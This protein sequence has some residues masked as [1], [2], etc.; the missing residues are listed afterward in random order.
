MRA[1]M[2]VGAPPPTKP[3]L[4]R[5]LWTSMAIPRSS[6]SFLR[7]STISF[8][9]SDFCIDYTFYPLQPNGWRYPLVGGT[10]CRCFAGTNLQPETCLKTRRLPPVGCT[11]CWAAAWEVCATYIGLFVR[12]YPNSIEV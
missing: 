3:I 1:L 2:T 12:H 6:P 9:V 7:S 4:L 8:C 11:P 5:E 10:R